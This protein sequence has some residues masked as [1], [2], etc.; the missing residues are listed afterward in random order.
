MYDA[1]TTRYAF[2]CPDRGQARVALSSFRRIEQLPGATHPAVFEVDFDCGCGDRHPGLVTHDELD[3]APL[4]LAEGVFLNLMTSQ[5]D[6]VEDELADLAA[7][8]IGA[9]EWPWSFFCYPEERPRPIFPSSFFLLAPAQD[10]E[11]VGI[12]V[13]CPVCGS[14]SV[15]LVSAAHVDVPFHNDAQIWIVEHVFQ[16]DAER[17]L[18]EF[19]AELYS[20]RFDARRLSL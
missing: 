17:A 11:A 7:R 8:R 18:E 9:G 16:A 12:A 19:A 3:W 15:N 20:A 10:R 14:V 6:A 13:R 2:S 4:G 1:L 5:L